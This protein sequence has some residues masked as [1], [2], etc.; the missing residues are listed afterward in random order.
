MRSVSRREPLT[1][2]HALERSKNLRTEM[3]TGFRDMEVSYDLGECAPKGWRQKA[4][5]WLGDD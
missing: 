3:R 4:L 5:W 2:S 1:A